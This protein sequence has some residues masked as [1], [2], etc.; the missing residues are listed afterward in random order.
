MTVRNFGVDLGGG[1][2]SESRVDLGRPRMNGGSMATNSAMQISSTPSHILIGSKR[3]KQAAR[4][5]SIFSADARLLKDVKLV[6]E[7]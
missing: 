1:N 4:F 6:D 5:S 7:P 2:R 3:L